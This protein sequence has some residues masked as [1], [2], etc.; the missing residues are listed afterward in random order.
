VSAVPQGVQALH[1]IWAM[2]RKR[3]IGTGI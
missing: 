3:C 2:Q 1:S